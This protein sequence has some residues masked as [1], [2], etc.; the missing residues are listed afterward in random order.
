M[1]TCERDL[2]ACA[3]AISSAH[4]LGLIAVAEG[5]ETAGQAELLQQHDCDFLQGFYFSR[6]LTGAQMR[7]FLANEQEDATA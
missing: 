3:A 1:E 5:V 4:A 7:E 6:P 2:A